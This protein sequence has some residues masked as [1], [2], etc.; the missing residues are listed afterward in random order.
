MEE[1]SERLYLAQL[2]LQAGTKAKLSAAYEPA[3]AY[4]KAGITTLSSDCWQTQY[5]LSFTLYVQAI[6]CAYLSKE[7]QEAETLSDRA[8]TQAKTI[9]EQVK[10]YELKLFLNNLLTRFTEAIQM[11]YQGLKLLGYSVPTTAAQLQGMTLLGLVKLKWNLRNRKIADLLDLP[12]M[13]V[14]EQQAAISLLEAL[15]LPAYYVN[16]ALLNFAVLKMVDLSLKFGNTNASVFAYATFGFLTG[17][18][19]GDYQSG[20]EYG[21][22]AI[23]LADN[24]Q[25]DLQKTRAYSSMGAYISPWY[26]NLRESIHYLKQGF[27]SGLESGETTYTDISIYHLVT[28][29]MTGGF[30]LEEVYEVSQKRLALGQKLGVATVADNELLLQRAI[31]GQLNPE[32]FNVS[33]EEFDVTELEA[34]L[35]TS[36][37]RIQWC[38]Y[39]IRKLQVLYLLGN[40]QEALQVASTVE[41]TI[42]V[43]AFGNIEIA[44]FYFYH[45]LILLALYKG[46]SKAQQQQFLKTIDVYQKKL[47]R[48]AAICSDNFS[49]KHLLIEAQIAQFSEQVWRAADLYDRAIQAA[50]TGGFTQN[51]AIANE[52][53]GEFHLSLGK[54]KIAQAYLLDAYYGYARWGATAIAETIRER[55]ADLLSYLTTVPGMGLASSATISLAG[56]Q[57]RTTTGKTTTGK[58]TGSQILDLATVVK[59]SQA[60]SGEIVLERLLS[61]LL[62][63]TMENAGAEKGVLVLPQQGEWIL[64]ATGQY[65]QTDSLAMQS[66]SLVSSQDLPLSILNYVSRTQELLVIHDAKSEKIFAADS[67]LSEHQPCSILCFPILHQANIAGI[68]YLENSQLVEA[69]TSARLE[70]LSI[71]SAQMATSLENAGLYQNLQTVNVALQESN[72]SLQASEAREKEKAVQLE[73]SIHNLQ[74]TQAQ[75]VQTE[76]ISSLGQLVAGVAHEVNNP[77]SFITGNLVHANSYTQDL[78]E[79]IRLYQKYLPDPPV[80]VIEK[81]E[82][83]ELEYLLEDL[84]QMLNS[85]QTGTER[86]RDIMSSLRT[87][88]RVDKS[89]VLSNLHDGL[90]STLLILGH[91]IKANSERPAIQLIK[92]YGS[93]PQVECFAGQVNQVFMNLLA[94]A[95]DALDERCAQRSYRENE[96][97]LAKIQIQT[98]TIENQ[99]VRITISDNGT[100]M[101]ESVRQKL[102]APFFTTKPS[103]KGTG[104]GLSIS[105]QIITEQ[106]KG[107]IECISESG[108]GTTFMIEVPVKNDT[109]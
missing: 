49:H 4:F 9:L 50:Q 86:I 71:L 51:Q 40:Y 41:K 74:Q 37:I 59:A 30:P 43:D 108:K 17:S 47:K 18:V 102:F 72:I 84:P 60:I 32:Q 63:V 75:L 105:H 56:E 28:K 25:D 21:E 35:R 54:E 46:S 27:Q 42:H 5:D 76:K 22:V 29:L 99:Q 68:L 107:R 62:Q 100:G 39:Q 104:L 44:E 7:F 11:G 19:L 97:D 45:S 70:V 52:L 85:M 26:K 83:V 38:I 82:Q 55:H 24:C 90:E 95:I 8:L 109:E 64:A 89:K 80:E 33:L 2:N 58:T 69:F 65:D 98:R 106:H 103:S 57:T 14:L 3:F 81:I 20:Y 12:K 92:E 77:V 15:L 67:Y 101:P 16:Q 87:F 10:I 53:A 6:E 31:L 66:M 13:T 34:Q 93:I 36:T 91:R 23:H 96:Q 94:N 79:L 61:T 88:S 73:K 78:I 1:P 48:W